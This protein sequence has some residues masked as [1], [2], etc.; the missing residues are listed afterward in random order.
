M[1]LFLALIL[2]IAA[3]NFFA[4]KLERSKVDDKY[5]WNLSEIYPSVDAWQ[6]EVN[7]ISAKIDKLPDYKGKLGSNAETLYSALKTYFDILKS[8]YSTATYAS[9][10]SNEDLNNSEN[11]ALDQQTTSIGTKFGENTA[12]L[13][14]EI[15]QIPKEKM[16]Q[17]FKE[18]PELEEF[19]MYIDNIQRL[20]AHTLTE[21]EEKILASFGLIAGNQND[22]YGIFNN[23]EKPAP[24]VTL[25]TC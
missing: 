15:L 17:F 14:P 16:Q 22:V 19:S 13:E 18:K 20:Q 7:N 23:A 5:K 21:A 12:F 8:F 1:K 24:V 2:L 4:Q 9:N 3:N 11:Q 25:S 6:T 10:L